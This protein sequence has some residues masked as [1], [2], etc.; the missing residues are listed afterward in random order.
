MESIRV[1]SCG[2]RLSSSRKS[3]R[4][5]VSCPDK[6]RRELAALVVLVLQ[7][8]EQLVNEKLAHEE[9]PEPKTKSNYCRS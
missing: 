5:T 9:V 7:Q 3:V 1:A 6:V 4:E 8:Q 2:S